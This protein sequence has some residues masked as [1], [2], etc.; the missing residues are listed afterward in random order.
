MILRMMESSIAKNKVVVDAILH[1]VKGM[2]EEI[3]EN[4]EELNPLL[5]TPKKN[6]QS[7]QGYFK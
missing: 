5:L 6:N 4:T 7:P 2:K 1:G 3:D